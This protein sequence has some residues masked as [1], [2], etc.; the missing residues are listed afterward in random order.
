MSKLNFIKVVSVMAALLVIPAVVS[1]QQVGGTVT[2]TTGGVLPGVTV[3]ARSPALIEGVRSAVTDGNGNYL[4]V[5]L[6]TGDYEVTYSLP[7]FG[8]V[9]REGIELSTGFTANID[10]QLSVGDIEETITVSGAT[11]VVDIQNVEQRAVMDREVIDSIPTGKSL[12]SYGL[13]VP[14]MTGAE[15]YGTSLSQD[16]GGLTSQTLQRLSIHG[17]SQL[18]QTVN[19]NGMD[20]GD[21][22]TQGANMAYFPDTNF[23]EI[24]YNYSA[25]SAEVETGGVSISMIPREGS[26]SFSG[27]FFTTFTR[28]S[29]HANNLDQS[30]MDAGLTSSTE[31][32]NNWTVAPSFGGP[33]VEDK[34]WFFL[35][36]TSQQADITAAGAYQATDPRA[37]VFV[38]DLTKP[39]NDES[40]V[41]EQSLNLTYQMTSKDKIKAYWTNSSTDKPLYLQGRTLTSIFISPEA[42]V[43]SD[44]R[45]NAYQLAWVRPHTNR[46]LFEAGVSHQ[47]VQFSLKPSPYAQTDIPGVLE[48]S[49]V[50]A[51]RNMTAWL[52]GPTVRESPKMIN[53]YRAAVSYVTGSH[54]LKVGV[55]ALTQMIGVGQE[56]D[57]NWLAINTYGGFPIRINYYGSSTSENY[58][59]PTLGIYAQ[60]QWTLDRLTVNAGVRFDYI[61]AGYP[62]QIRPTNDWV[63]EPFNVP[64]AVALT[65]KDLQPRLGLAYDLAGDGKTALKFSASRYGARDSTDWAERLN[66]ALS[67]RR[68]IRSWND[69]YTGCVSGTCIVGDGLPQ[70]DP[71]NPSP[72][73]ELMSAN[74]DLSFGVP[75]IT[76][77]YDQSWAFGWGNRQSNWEIS[78]SVQ[79]ELMEGVSLDVGYFRRNQVNIS[80]LDDRNVS[81]SDFD[82][83]TVTVPTDQNLP[84]GGG[85]TLSFY[86]LQPGAA[87]ASDELRGSDD[88]FGGQSSG[89]QGVDVTIDARIDNLLLQGGLSTGRAAHDYCD[90]AAALPETMRDFNAPVPIR[91]TFGD[92]APIN[93]CNRTE[94]WLTQVKLLGSYTL[95]YGIQVA[96]TLQNQSG[97][98]RAAEALFTTTDLGR[99]MTQY[100]SGVKLNLIQPGSEYGDR[101]SQFDVRLTKIFELGGSGTALRA[102]FDIFNVFNANTVTMEQPAYGANWLTPQVIM[103]GRL[104]KFAFQLDF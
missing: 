41:R 68:M 30:L 35:T 32:V 102:M 95:P 83:A 66:P 14:G 8:S 91:S 97:P 31:V 63:T 85:G 7:G 81:A 86:D 34:L 70:G 4:I 80:A 26:N 65:W 50:S 16:S 2:D 75:A 90:L 79:R 93:Y 9:L 6:E 77:F 101:F 47:P 72:N 5:G 88:A 21:A 27:N 17:G 84:G 44:I 40:T 52:S 1:A 92:T 76:R 3:E 10:I 104:A 22:F 19:V 51:S 49:P 39:T 82:I 20:V 13:L 60:E 100:A 71:N 23:E 96:G 12:T 59:S 55:T 42:A 87:A 103:P 25:N 57:A 74:T 54:N 38:P 56:S 15:S 58:A 46:L 43:D 33:I 94:N 24:A 62:D 64:G 53:S 37:L 98:M 29:L 45:T 18:D 67:N 73:G 78:A 61:K 28:P 36:H 69:G 99:S 11:P 89:W 48:F